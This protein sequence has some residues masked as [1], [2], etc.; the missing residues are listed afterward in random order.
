MNELGTWFYLATRVATVCAGTKRKLVI[1]FLHFCLS[2]QCIFGSLFFLL[3]HLFSGL[4][5]ACLFLRKQT[6]FTQYFMSWTTIYLFTHGT[7]ALID[8][9]LFFPLLSIQTKFARTMKTDWSE[10]MFR[11]DEDTDLVQG[12]ID[13][14]EQVTSK[15]SLR[16]QVHGIFRTSRALIS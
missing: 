6:V 7:V 8:K 9:R 13:T 5:G 10:T 11:F 1:W 2:C 16:L 4:D 15:S 12:A 3:W 14:Y